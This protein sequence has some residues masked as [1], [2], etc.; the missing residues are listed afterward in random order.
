MK[1]ILLPHFAEEE[2]KSQR[3]KTK[4]RKESKEKGRERGKEGS[5]SNRREIPLLRRNFI[6]IKESS[7]LEDKIL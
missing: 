5:F 1:E 7:V 4:E 6:P 2:S 3:G